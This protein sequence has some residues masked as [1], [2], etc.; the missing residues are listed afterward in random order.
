MS[1][2]GGLMSEP[3]SRIEP[4]SSYPQPEGQ[5]VATR[6]KEKV[7]PKRAPVDAAEAA[8]ADADELE[9]HEL[10]TLA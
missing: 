1:R 3:T 7:R 9:K 6:M 2:E 8:A 10:D 4:T 5:S